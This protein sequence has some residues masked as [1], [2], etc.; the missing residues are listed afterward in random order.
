MK[1]EEEFN[2]D[3]RLVSPEPQYR[4]PVNDNALRPKLLSEYI[5]QEQVKK[6]LEVFIGAAR[7]RGNLLIM[8]FFMAFPALAKRH[9]L[10]LFQMKWP[11]TL[12]L[13]P[14]R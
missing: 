3:E 6:S 14:A 4:E 12:K 1:I 5:G 11:V 8:F 13:L 7:Q 9:F 2:G 10:T